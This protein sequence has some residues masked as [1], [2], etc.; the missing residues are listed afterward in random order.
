VIEPKLTTIDYPGY[1]IGEAAASGLINIL[2]GDATTEK[3]TKLVLQATLLV[4][5]SSKRLK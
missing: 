3:A 4:R 1:N 5:A 2:K